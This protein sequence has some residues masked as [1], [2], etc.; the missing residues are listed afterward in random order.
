M[1]IRQVASLLQGTVISGCNAWLP[2]PPRGERSAWQ[3]EEQRYRSLVAIAERHFVGVTDLSQ[4][5][6]DLVAAQRASAANVATGAAA[7]GV[8]PLPAPEQY[9]EVLQALQQCVPLAHLLTCTCS[10]L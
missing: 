1:G 6:P 5:L 8:V 4:L 9:G 3:A 7:P 10:S 2:P